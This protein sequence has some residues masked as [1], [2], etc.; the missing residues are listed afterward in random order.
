MGVYIK[1]SLRPW[2]LRQNQGVAHSRKV[3]VDCKESSHM[4]GQDSVGGKYRV[5][6]H[7]RNDTP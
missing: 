3:G 5:R 2:M 7:D 6:L 4:S 1:R